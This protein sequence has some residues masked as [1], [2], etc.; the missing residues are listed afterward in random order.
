MN[1]YRLVLFLHIA[2]AAL[3]IG[4]SLAGIL[5]RSAVRRSSTPR[6]IA[7]VLAL[8]RPLSVMNPLSAFSLLGTGIYLTSMGRWWTAPWVLVAMLTWVVNVVIA[9]GAVGRAVERLAGRVGT[10]VEGR[11]DPDLD[12]VRPS[13]A[14][15]V[16]EEKAAVPELIDR[17]C[18]SCAHAARQA[19]SELPGMDTVR[20]E[21]RHLTPE[22]DDHNR[23]PSY[24]I[25]VP[26]RPKLP[27]AFASP[28]ESPDQLPIRT[29]DPH[30][31]GAG[32]HDED[33]PVG[34]P[35]GVGHLIEKLCRVAFRTPDPQRRLLGEGPGRGPSRPRKLVFH[36]CDPG[37]GANESGLEAKK[38]LPHGS[39]LAAHPRRKPPITPN[40][41]PTMCSYATLTARTMVG[42]LLLFAAACGDSP[43]DAP[44]GIQP[45]INNL[46][47][48]FSYQVT[49]LSNVTGT[50]DYE[51]ENGGTLAKVTHASD[52]GAAGTAT[53]TIR[54]G[55]GTQ[56]Y[57]GPFDTSGETVT[58]PAG[59]AGTWMITVTYSDYSN[60][61]V[62]FAVVR[63]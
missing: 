24:R 10:T 27:R 19:E 6:E 47:D 38:R 8:G 35:A 53:V 2:S 33:P 58:S 15:T 1:A 46:A 52:A 37:A 48:A 40:W 55:A 45:Q 32:A 7:A 5:F 25:G 11:L 56:V 60:T 21:D 18:L 50:W 14:W 28:S 49:S 26:G 51:W 59:V 29:V 16:G 30:L 34:E 20:I 63:Q 42:A 62:N 31:R 23:V 54:D 43:T 44:P 9:K 17:L 12:M 4:G 61:Q 22:V 41:I 3:L 13:V 39:I 57:S 36:D